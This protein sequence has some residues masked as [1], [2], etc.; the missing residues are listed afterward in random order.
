LPRAPLL[1]MKKITSK[2]CSAHPLNDPRFKAWLREVGLP[3]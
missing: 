3:A 2:S 1:G